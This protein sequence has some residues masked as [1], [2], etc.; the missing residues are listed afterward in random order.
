M[1]SLSYLTWILTLPPLFVLLIAFW[2]MLFATYWSLSGSPITCLGKSWYFVWFFKY[3]FIKGCPWKLVFYWLILS[4]RLSCCCKIVCEKFFLDLKMYLVL[5]TTLLKSAFIFIP[6]IISLSLSSKL[7]FIF[8][9]KKAPL[10]SADQS[11]ISF[12]LSTTCLHKMMVP[13]SWDL[14]LQFLNWYLSNSASSR[15]ASKFLQILIIESKGTP[16][17]W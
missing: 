9:L 1:S 14:R 2:M 6:W 12:N 17:F 8:L 15:L 10:S 5:S 7:K 16:I 11:Y 13:V 3:L 4:N